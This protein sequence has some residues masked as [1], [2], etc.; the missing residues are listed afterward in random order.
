[1]LISVGTECSDPYTLTPVMV[2]GLF[3]SVNLHSTKYQGL[4]PIPK[5]TALLATAAFHIDLPAGLKLIWYGQ[6]DLCLTVE[7]R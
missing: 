5:R 2:G 1:M 4:L 3:P 7:A 6:A